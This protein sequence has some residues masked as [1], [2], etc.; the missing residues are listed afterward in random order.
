MNI[1]A[2]AEL[3]EERKSPRSDKDDG[4]WFVLIRV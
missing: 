3:N 1:K 2:A 4:R